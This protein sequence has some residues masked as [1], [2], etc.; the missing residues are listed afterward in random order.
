MM[1]RRK[2]EEQADLQQ[3]IELQSRRLLNLQ[4]PDLKNNSIH[5]R[6]LSV[7][8]PISLPVHQPSRMHHENVLPSDV[9]E[10]FSIED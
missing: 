10:G 6:S 2:L 5:H 3:A 8:S 4:L 7:G 9:S 1:L